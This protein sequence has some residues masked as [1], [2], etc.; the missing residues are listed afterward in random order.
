MFE[1]F[2]GR[3][4]EAGPIAALGQERIGHGIVM[5]AAVLCF[6]FVSVLCFVRCP[7]DVV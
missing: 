3:F 7:P 5:L 6:S 2:D 4:P 1:P